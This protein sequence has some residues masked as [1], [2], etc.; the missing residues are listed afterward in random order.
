MPY[1]ALCGIQVCQSPGRA[2]HCFI[3]TLSKIIRGQRI[4][5]AIRPAR[6]F[7]IIVIGADFF[8]RPAASTTAVATSGTA[9]LCRSGAGS[10]LI[11]PLALPL[12]RVISLSLKLAVPY[13]RITVSVIGVVQPSS[14]NVLIQC[15]SLPCINGKSEGFNVA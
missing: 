11:L 10:I 9:S 14:T 6:R 1:S 3:T 13:S 4:A 7:V 5:R 12:P 8:T 15:R 2:S